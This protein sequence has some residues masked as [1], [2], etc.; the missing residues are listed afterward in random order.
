MSISEHLQHLKIVLQTLLENQ[1]FAKLS[2]CQFCQESIEYLG[3]IV[4]ISGVQ[5][6]PKKIQTMLEWSVPKNLKQLRVFIGLTGYYRKFIR[7]YASIAFPLTNLLKKDA[8]RWDDSAQSSFEELKMKMIQA[9]VLAMPDFSKPFELE[10]DA[11][12]H[13]I[14]AVLMQDKHPIAFFS[15]KNVQ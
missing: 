14:G 6:D 10:T 4:S 2:K 5:A 15:K 1:L 13:A 12:G 7:N 9:P 11:S 3:H 8:F